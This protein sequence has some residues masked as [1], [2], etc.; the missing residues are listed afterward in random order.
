MINIK[1][2]ESVNINSKFR[3]EDCM[4]YLCL[5]ELGYSNEL[6]LSKE[7]QC[8]GI[9]IKYLN[10]KSV[11]YNTFESFIRDIED[12]SFL[13]NKEVEYIINIF[14]FN[15]DNFS[16]FTNYIIGITTKNIESMLKSVLS[17]CEISFRYIMD[18]TKKV[19]KIY[20]EI[21]NKMGDK[22]YIIFDDID[23]TIHD[24]SMYIIYDKIV[25]ENAD[26]IIYAMF[27]D[28]KIELV[29]NYSEEL[30]NKLYKYCDEKGF[31][32]YNKLIFVKDKESAIKLVEKYLT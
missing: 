23:L 14:Y 28:Y 1:N 7:N 12:D 18:N 32:C 21:I 26:C 11:L 22:K 17:Y 13:D 15:L 8:N 31:K 6:I 30:L 4:I 27:N 5:K 25:H 19:K 9:E 10:S 24:K 16:K 2:I 20:E 29:K 3:Y